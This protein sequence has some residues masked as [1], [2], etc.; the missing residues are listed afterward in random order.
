MKTMIEKRMLDLEKALA[1]NKAKLLTND[2][3]ILMLHDIHNIKTGN[4][5]FVKESNA[6]DRPYSF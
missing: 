1:E 6:K 2:L 4:L 5:V 3:K